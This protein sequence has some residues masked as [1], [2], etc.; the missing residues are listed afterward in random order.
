MS[1][2]I[3]GCSLRK[4]GLQMFHAQQQEP[5]KGR[6][7]GMIGQ[8]EKTEQILSRLLKDPVDTSVLLQEMPLKI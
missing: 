3:R 4:A 6:E 8:V 2:C 5:D 1:S 7:G